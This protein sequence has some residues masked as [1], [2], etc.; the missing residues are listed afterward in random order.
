MQL[1]SDK[2]IWIPDDEDW[3]KWGGN[4]E[5]IEFDNI[6]NHHISNWDVALDV[7]AHVGIWST[8]LAERFKKVI[9]F[10]PVPKHIECWKQNMQRFT[11]EHSEWEN[12]RILET[13][14]HSNEN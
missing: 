10:E 1:T 4:Y 7:G 8:R 9:A 13:V 3:I 5:Q 6:M 11:S 2:R 12:A 14:A